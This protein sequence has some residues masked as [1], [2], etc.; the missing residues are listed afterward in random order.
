MDNVE[1]FASFY[2]TAYYIVLL[3]LSIY[4]T[5]FYSKN[6]TFLNCDI[7]LPLAIAIIL[8]LAFRPLTY[9]FGFGDTQGYAFFF[10]LKK[11]QSGIDLEAKDLGYEFITYLLRGFDV[12]TLFMIMGTLYVV[13]QFLAAKQLTPKHYGILFLIIVC[14]FSFWGYGVNGMRN[15]AALSLVML[16]M[17][18][19][20][21]IWT[22]ILFLCGLSFHGSAFLPISAYCLNFIYSKSGVYMKVWCVCVVLSL[23]VS[24]FLTEILP[25]EDLIND[26]RVGYLSNEFDSSNS[27]KFSA[28]GYRWDFVLYSAIPILLGYRQISSGAVKDRIYKYLYNTYCTCNA[29]WLFTIY[30]PYNN[31]FAY[32]SWFLYPLIV[33]YPFLCRKDNITESNV[34]SVRNVIGITYLFTFIMWLK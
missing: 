29:F 28:T 27:D 14:S 12:W 34:Q 21:V 6:N 5:L 32:L 26:D 2:S 19:R 4:A 1:I 18:K 24:N 20:N 22:P 30:V 11:T 23:F 33:T 9:K 10:E 31:R 15:G 3:L 7:G 17:V 8:F 16:G 13:P 25:L